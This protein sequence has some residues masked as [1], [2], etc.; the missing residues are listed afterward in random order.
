MTEQE[1][2]ELLEAAASSHDPDFVEY[3]LQ[4]ADASGLKPTYVPALISI[5]KSPEHHSHEDIVSAL[6]ILKDP[7]AAEALFNAALIQH[8]YLVYD[9]RF[10]LARKCTWALADIGTP[11]A[12]GYLERLGASSNTFIAAHAQKRLD[13]WEN[14][15]DRK[16]WHQ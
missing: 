11:D 2:I 1:I 10:A 8:E 15:K 3:A 14:E 13:N 4:C 7:R 6:Q 16:G 5:L 12:R 9:E